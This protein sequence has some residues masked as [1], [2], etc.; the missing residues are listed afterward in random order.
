MLEYSKLFFSTDIRL[1]LQIY[2]FFYFLGIRDYHILTGYNPMDNVA[3]GC[4]GNV[5]S[6]NG[7][8]TH[9]LR[10]YFQDRLGNTCWTKWLFN[11]ARW[12]WNRLGK[13]GADNFDTRYIWNGFNWYQAGC[14]SSWGFYVPNKVQEYM[15]PYDM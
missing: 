7:Y 2:K 6:Y 5:H 9:D 11:N 1:F 3:G 13:N 4:T 8:C 12:K 10:M 14:A 15:I